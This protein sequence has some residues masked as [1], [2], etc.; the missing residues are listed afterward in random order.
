MYGNASAWKLRSSF[1]DVQ[2]G[3]VNSIRLHR[4][5][6]Q[7]LVWYST[8][9]CN[10]KAEILSFCH[11][12]KWLMEVKCV[13]MHASCKMDEYAVHASTSFGMPLVLHTVRLQRQYT[14]VDR[15]WKCYYCL[16]LIFTPN[17]N[18]FRVI[19]FVSPRVSASACTFWWILLNHAWYH[20]KPHPKNLM[21]IACQ[22]II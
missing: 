5:G 11:S 8:P 6:D 2:W 19:V 1:L 14:T 9:F 12:T 17:T 15:V 10:C 18:K 3:L 7:T 4:C 13:C 22:W 16:H 21:R 20:V